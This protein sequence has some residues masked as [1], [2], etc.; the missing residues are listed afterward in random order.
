MTLTIALSM[1]VKNEA[2]FIIPTLTYLLPYIDHYAIS[3]TGSDDNTKDIITTFL[4]S[5]HKSFS[6]TSDTWVD[7]ATNRNIVLSTVLYKYDYILLIDADEHCIISD[8]SFKQLL[9]TD[10]HI[11]YRLPTKH[12]STAN[13]MSSKRK[14]ISGHLNWKYEDK[15]HEQLRCF[16]KHQKTLLLTDS[17][18]HIIHTRLTTPQK[19][20]YYQTLMEEILETNPN[21][22]ST[23]YHYANHLRHEKKYEKAIS[24]YEHVIKTYADTLHINQLLN[25]KFYMFLC[26]YRILYSFKQIKDDLQ[27]FIELENTSHFILEPIYIGILIL[28]RENNHIQAYQLGKPYYKKHISPNIQCFNYYISLYNG[29]YDIKINQLMRLIHYSI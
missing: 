7:F 16:S 20:A 8:Q 1:I 12:S 24:I 5:H 22:Y 19:T 17:T 15:V 11:S 10:K 28:C 29:L 26:K 6:L 14:L 9:S 13:H 21:H 25:L 4:H 3:D 18:I 2:N 27:F 23:L